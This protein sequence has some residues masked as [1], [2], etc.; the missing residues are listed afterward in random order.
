VP[1]Q[2]VREARRPAV[3][4]D[5]AGADQLFE[6]V[7]LDHREHCVELGA[8]A[9][10]DQHEAAVG[11]VEHAGAV[12][13]EAAQQAALVGL[14]VHA[15]LEQR[16]LG[17][18]RLRHVAHVVGDEH[19]VHELVDLLVDLLDGLRGAAAHDRHARKALD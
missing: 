19:D 9:I 8:G 7:R 2:Q 5:L 10:G 16:D 4:D 12:T 17:L 3:H 14:T 15:H 18:H 13:L 11:L 6:R 1:A